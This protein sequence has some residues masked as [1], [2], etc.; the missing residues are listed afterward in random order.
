MGACVPAHGLS[1]PRADE[2]PMVDLLLGA[3]VALH[4][5]AQ[6]C[7]VIPWWLRSAYVHSVGGTRQCS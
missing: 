2:E 3:V 7:A 4:E 5:G 6:V 1:M